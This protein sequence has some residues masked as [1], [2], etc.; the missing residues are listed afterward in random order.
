MTKT[1]ASPPWRLLRVLL[2]LWAAPAW[3]HWGMPDEASSI[4]VR[5]GHEDDWIMG[6][7]SGA[8]I[9]RD[10][11]A[12]WKWICPEGMGIA[13]W[14]P[15]RYF[16]LAS[17]TL[18][19]ATGSALVRSDDAGCTWAPHLFFKDTWVTSLAVHPT[20][21]RRLYVSTGRPSLSNGLYRSE[22]GGETWTLARPPTPGSR[23]S[24]IRIAA[25]DPRRLY[26]SGED[27]QGL[28]LARS[29]DGGV[30]W[31]RLSQA[32]PQLQLPFDLILLRVSDASPDVLWARVTAQGR[33][34]LLKST[35]G[36]V[37]MTA[38]MDT[39]ER[40]A[41]TEASEDGRT[42]WV[43]TS[44]RMYRSQDDSAFVALEEP[45]GNACALKSG[46]VLYGCGASWTGGWALARS[47][48]EGTTWDP[49]FRLRDIQGAHACPAGTPV[50]R[51]CPALWPQMAELFGA[52]SGVDGGAVPP[53]DPVAPESPVEP[54]PKESCAAAPGLVPAAL[55]LVAAALLRRSRGRG[56]PE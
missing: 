7:P 16:W 34:V 49:M 38:V 21:E 17:G 43:S 11:G 36:G 15:E 54:A 45:N 40:I 25:S 50:Q 14:R 12:T 10:R 19:A 4:N 37:T 30:T 46:G 42:V 9:S 20:D 2:A 51:A 3:A 28:F 53:P 48:D 5:R 33:D 1:S 18:L 56:S 22:D 52:P 13:I 41:S 26:A 27:A 29:D 47:A 23:F 24:S 55:G 39:Y 35:D 44:T 32:L 8:L 31:S 6:D